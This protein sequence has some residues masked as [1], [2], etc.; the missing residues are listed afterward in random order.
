M[1]QTHYLSLC[2]AVSSEY[3]RLAKFCLVAEEEAACLLASLLLSRGNVICF[4]SVFPFLSAHT[5]A[6]LLSFPPI[7]I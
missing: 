7:L 3:Q 6:F 2:W 1:N 5:R 4:F